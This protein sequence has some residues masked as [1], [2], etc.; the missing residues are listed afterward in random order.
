M[1]YEGL[2]RDI[3]ERKRMDE[4]RIAKEAAEKTAQSKNEFRPTSAMKSGRR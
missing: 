3:T 1:Y 4:L 2:L